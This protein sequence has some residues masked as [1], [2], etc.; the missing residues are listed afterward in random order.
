MEY[1]VVSSLS[2][3][4]CAHICAVRLLIILIFKLAQVFSSWLTSQDDSCA[5]LERNPVQKLW[6]TDFL[7]FF[8]W[9][10][11]LSSIK[12]G[13]HFTFNFLFSSMLLSHYLATNSIMLGC[14][15]TRVLQIYCE[16]NLDLILWMYFT[17]ILGA[18]RDW[19]LHNPILRRQEVDAGYDQWDFRHVAI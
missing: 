1:S 6:G 13:H 17:C 10:F 5:V 19:H 11:I 16:L 18:C 9:E 15:F 2:L 4:Q 8:F 7:F 14:N 3:Q 12:Q